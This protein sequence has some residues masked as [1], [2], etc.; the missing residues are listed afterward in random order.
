MR[1]RRSKIE[2]VTFEVE[3]WAAADKAL[4][5][6]GDLE[7]D[8]TSIQNRAKAAIDEIKAEAADHTAKNNAKIKAI[9]KGLEVFALQNKSEFSGKSKKLGFGSIGWRKS[10]AIKISKHT[11]T[12]I[13]KV[14]SKAKAANYIKVKET[15]NKTALASLTD[16][17]LA[18][19][20]ARREGRESFYAEPD[21]PTE[22]DYE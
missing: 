16:E 14:F 19:V 11:L 3:S 12:L 17:Q 9:T 20:E 8:N 18:G 1:K 4:K 15:V 13:K 6:L 5:Q 10:T 2:A 21:M 7:L 22:V